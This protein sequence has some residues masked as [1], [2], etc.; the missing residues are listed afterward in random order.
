[1][2]QNPSVESINRQ[3][4]D[5][6][7]TIGKRHALVLMMTARNGKYAELREKNRVFNKWRDATRDQQTFTVQVE[8]AR[9]AKEV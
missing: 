6:Q 1:M 9:L 5:N 7:M 8:M 3:Q 4:N 2:N